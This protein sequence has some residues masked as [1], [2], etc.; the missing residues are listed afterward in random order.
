MPKI[1]VIVPVYNV[2]RYVGAAIAS[3][4]AQSFT[5][6]EVIAVDDGSPDRS[7]DVL[8]SIADDRI[9][10]V[11]QTNRGLAGA[12]N[13]GIRAARGA[14]IAMLDADDL[15]HPKKLER[16]ADHLS[17][18]PEIGVSFCHSALIDDEGNDLGKAQTPRADRVTAERLL[19]SNPL[20]NGSTAVLRREVFDDVAFE[21]NGRIQYFDEGLRRSQ[22]VE[23]LDLWLRIAMTTNW[24]IECLPEILTCY[25]LNSAGLS[26][27]GRQMVASWQRVVDKARSFDPE[28]VSRCE[29]P[30][31]A[32]LL[33]YLASRAVQA[34]DPSG[35]WSLIVDA[36]KNDPSILWK[37]MRPTMSTLAATLAAHVLPD[38]TYRRV[39][40]A[41]RRLES[42]VRRS[43]AA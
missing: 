5:D 13:A 22:G 19:L 30:A 7:F 27:D 38:S 32:R 43:K 39:E 14:W 10:I 9:R 1:S 25:R 18:H 8:S 42:T 12:R 26:V 29:R 34:G 28:L 21:S 11:R 33:R 36:L 23:D 16:H 20:S 15:F 31:R 40:H 35:A 24:Q 37:Q 6:F 3:V 17:R 41:A 2:E 4:L